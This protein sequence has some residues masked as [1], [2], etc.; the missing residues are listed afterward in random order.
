MI[1]KGLQVCLLL[2]MVGRLQGEYQEKNYKIKIYACNSQLILFCLFVVF[3]LCTRQ[4]NGSS[5]SGS[6]SG[7]A[8]HFNL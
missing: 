3:F 7:E 1:A 4:S 8:F 5:T 6:T 2:V